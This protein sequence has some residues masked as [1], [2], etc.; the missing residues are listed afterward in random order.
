MRTR[1][2]SILASLSASRV[3][4]SSSL[5]TSSSGDRIAPR[6]MITDGSG[7]ALADEIDT[8]PPAGVVTVTEEKVRAS[9]TNADPATFPARSRASST[10]NAPASPVLRPFPSSPRAELATTTRGILRGCCCALLPPL[11]GGRDGSNGGFEGANDLHGSGADDAAIR[12][13]SIFR[14][15]MMSVY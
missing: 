2:S 5:M 6:D 15:L 8:P 4:A 14:K 9:A 12:G 11:G 3:S 13:N 1:F 10:L 7:A